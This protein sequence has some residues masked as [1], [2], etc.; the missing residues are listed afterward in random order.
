M[1]GLD[2][3][4]KSRFRPP[5]GQRTAPHPMPHVPFGLFRI[6]QYRVAIVDGYLTM[7]GRGR[8]SGGGSGSGSGTRK[9]IDTLTRKGTGRGREREEGTR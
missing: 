4:L 1:S 8:V 7:D 3:R 9:G 6:C 2:T 5:V